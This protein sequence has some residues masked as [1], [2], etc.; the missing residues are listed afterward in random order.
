[1]KKKNKVFLMVMAVLVFVGVL[2]VRAAITTGDDLGSDGVSKIITETSTLTVTSVNA[3][4][5][6]SAYKILDAFYNA[7]TNVVSYEF[8]DDFQA[9]LD[10]ESNDLTIDDYFDLSSGDIVS[11]STTSTSELDTLASGY[12][13]YIKTNSVTGTEMNVA[14][15]TASATL[16]AGAYLVLPTE[17]LRVYAV[18]VGNLDY[19]A[20]GNGWSINSET[21]VAKVDDAGIT[22]GVGAEGVPSG[23][24]GIGDVVPYIITGTVPTYPTNAT[25]KTY[26]IHDTISSGLTFQA[27]TSMKI[28]DGDTPLTN[29]NGTFTNGTGQTVA[30]AEIQ[31]QNLTITFTVDNLTAKTV[32]VEYGATVNESAVVGG[33]GNSN[34]ATLEY[35]NDPY[36]DGTYN[37]GTDGDDED[38]VP[39]YVYGIDIFKHTQSGDTPLSGATFEIYKDSALEELVDTVTTG[40]DGHIKTKGLGEGTYYVKETKA[41]AGYQLLTDTL[42]VKIGPNQSGGEALQDTDTDGYYE[43]DVPNAEVGILPVT[44]G[45]GTII[46]TLVGL[47]IVGGAFYFFFVYRKKKQDQQQNA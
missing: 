20:D 25:N 5:K 35:S 2:N 34:S 38:I 24:Y 12:A 8:T 21:I 39:I 33:A 16:A 14:G 6:L 22:K 19:T 43:L 31:G 18:M 1:M 47:A 9:Y 45:V 30:V 46:I 29:N 36:G 44:G 40:E 28:S 13:A 15:T 10:E 3:G 17:T 37:T 11:G 23:S 27:V 7:N 26:V 41:P 32:K 4:D 42:T